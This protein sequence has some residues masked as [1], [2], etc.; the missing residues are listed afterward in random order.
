MTY[1]IYPQDANLTLVG[2]IYFLWKYIYRSV[3]FGLFLLSFEWNHRGHKP[4]LSLPNHVCSTARLAARPH[5]LRPCARQPRGCHFNWLW[6]L[7]RWGKQSISCNFT[8]SFGYRFNIGLEYFSTVTSTTEDLNHSGRSKTICA[9]SIP[10]AHLVT[11]CAD[12]AMCEIAASRRTSK[13]SLKPTSD[14]IP[15][16]KTI[17]CLWIKFKKFLALPV[18]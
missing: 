13:A 3:L 7:G 2:E 5:A 10:C 12:H 8:Y 6:A 15:R 1:L 16:Q 4:C 18:Q 17:L 14:K 11:S 9:W